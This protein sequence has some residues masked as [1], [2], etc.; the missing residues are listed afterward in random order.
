VCGPLRDLF[1]V[2]PGL[3]VEEG[4]QTGVVSDDGWALDKHE[5][6]AT[7]IE[8]GSAHVFFG[9]EQT[10][11]PAFG[12]RHRLAPIPAADRLHGTF[13]GVHHLLGERPEFRVLHQTR[14]P[15]HGSPRVVVAVTVVAGKAGRAGAG[16]VGEGIHERAC[17]GAMP[18]CVGTKTGKFVPSL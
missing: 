17:V 8:T 13:E 16:C 9:V 7:L 6:V 1:P 5:S 2:R 12:H 3:R 14:E 11:S 4:L 15:L 10:A 18:G